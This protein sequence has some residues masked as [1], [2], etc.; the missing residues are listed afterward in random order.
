MSFIDWATEE[1]V[2]AVVQA[3]NLIAAQT[4]ST[5][6]DLQQDKNVRIY[7]PV[8]TNVTWRLNDAIDH[9]WPVV[10]HPRRLDRPLHR[11]T[12]SVEPWTSSTR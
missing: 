12:S 10:T 11:R 3:T 1:T 7:E 4:R 5:T 8:F 2:N 6:F 9:P